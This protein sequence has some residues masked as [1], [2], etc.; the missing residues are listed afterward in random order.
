MQT[1]PIFPGDMRDEWKWTYYVKAFESY[2][3]TACECM[4]LVTCGHFRSRD[5]D[6]GHTSGSAMLK[7]PI[8]HANLMAL[9]FLELELWATKDY[10]AGIGIFLPFLLL[11][12]WPWPDDLHI[13]T[14]PVLPGDIPDVQIWSSHVKAFERSRLTEW[15]TYINTDWQTE[16]TAIINHTASRVVNKTF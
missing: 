1:W 7:N 2:H 5:K 13:R 6:G 11:W 16:P 3:I 9:P 8:T 10:I 4:H 14:W 12:P 15:Q